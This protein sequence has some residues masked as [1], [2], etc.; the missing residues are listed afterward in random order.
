MNAKDRFIKHASICF[1][2]FFLIMVMT[3]FSSKI[4]LGFFGSIALVISGTFFTTIGV[5]IGDVFCSFVRPDAFLSSGAVDTFKKK[6]FWMIGPQCIGWFIG[7]I[8][9]NGFMTKILGYQNLL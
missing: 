1:G 2:V 9:S 5:A 4:H 6:I 3:I 8:V 7:F